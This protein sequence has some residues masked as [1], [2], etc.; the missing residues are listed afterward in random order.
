MN[1]PKSGM[2]IKEIEVVAEDMCAVYGCNRCPGWVKAGD[3]TPVFCTHE[4]HPNQCD[5][6]AGSIDSLL[7]WDFPLGFAG[8][9][10]SSTLIV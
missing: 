8:G 6:E 7:S 10:A 2:D 1:A 9:S 5:A 4:C 3:G